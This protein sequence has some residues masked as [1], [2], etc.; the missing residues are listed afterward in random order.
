MIIGVRSRLGV[1]RTE[2]D[3]RVKIQGSPINELVREVLI[4]VSILPSY[5][6]APRH[7]P[8]PC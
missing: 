2:Q 8:H 3:E 1:L 7:W 6:E 4:E 5:Q